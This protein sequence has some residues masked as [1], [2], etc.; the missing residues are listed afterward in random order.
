MVHD[1]YED[2]KADFLLRENGRERNERTEKNAGRRFSREKRE[3]F[4]GKREEDEL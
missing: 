3:L 1:V 4:T 2:Y